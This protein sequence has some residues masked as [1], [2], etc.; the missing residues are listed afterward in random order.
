MSKS[1]TLI[2]RHQASITAPTAYLVTLH[3]PVSNHKRE[4][5]V[6]ST[7]IQSGIGPCIPSMRRALT[8]KQLFSP[9]TAS[10]LSR[11]IW[12]LMMNRPSESR[13]AGLRGVSPHR[14]VISVGV[15]SNT[16]KWSVI[17]VPTSYVDCSSWGTVQSWL[18]VAGPWYFLAR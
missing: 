2:N 13:G 7:S 1:A 4:Y 5:H 14:T 12:A 16:S 11:S 3:D 17:C 9:N 18:A 15:L 8:K 10:C 6:C